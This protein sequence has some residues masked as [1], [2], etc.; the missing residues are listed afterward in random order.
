MERAAKEQNKGPVSV[1]ERKLAVAEDQILLA[2]QVKVLD[3]H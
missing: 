2:V 3:H 1:A